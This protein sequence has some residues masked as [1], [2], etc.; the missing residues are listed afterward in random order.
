MNDLI[1]NLSFRPVSPDTWTDM[2][3]L[4]EG[5]GGPKFCWCMVYRSMV[6]P[7][8]RAD[9]ADKKGAMCERVAGG[10]PVGILAYIDGEPMAWCS[11]A[12]LS[13][14]KTFQGR[15]YARLRSDDDQDVDGV[16]AIA[17]LFVRTGFRR[18][19]LTT[20]IIKAAI[21]YA[22]RSGASSVEAYAVDP[23][24]PSYHFMGLVPLY[25][26]LGFEDLGMVGKRRHMMRLPL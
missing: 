7:Y 13:T 18:S 9:A 17:C 21:D 16:W 12:P 20:P 15:N 23:E 10:E 6:P 11:I 26:S 4:F 2:E 1:S 5:R 19:G 22:R 14:Y 3:R 25:E 8:S 24:S